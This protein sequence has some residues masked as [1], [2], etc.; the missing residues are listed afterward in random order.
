MAIGETPLPGSCAAASGTALPNGTSKHSARRRI[1][2]LNI[3]VLMVVSSHH[4]RSKIA[5][6]QK[7]PALVAEVGRVVV[8]FWASLRRSHQRVAR[9]LVS[10][11]NHWPGPLSLQLYSITTS[12]CRQRP[13]GTDSQQVINRPRPPVGIGQVVFCLCQ[14]APLHGQVGMAHQPLEGDEVN[15]AA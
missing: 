5:S 1:N 11:S 4:P 10:D 9:P 8:S 12:I 2:T 14:V 6:Q 3:F 15:A 7:H 13:Q